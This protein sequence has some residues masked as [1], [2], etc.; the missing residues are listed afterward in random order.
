MAYS[1]KKL[2]LLS[3][4][5]PL[6]RSIT[7]FK[8]RFLKKSS[9]WS[10]VHKSKLKKNNIRKIKLIN[11]INKYYY[12]YGSG[13]YSSIYSNNRDSFIF[14]YLK[15]NKT[16]KNKINKKSKKTIKYSLFYFI[17]RFRWNPLF[18]KTISFL[19]CSFKYRNTALLSLSIARTFER[20]HKHFLFMSYFKKILNLL[21]LYYYRRDFGIVRGYIIE[22]NGKFNG[23][24][25]SKKKLISNGRMP[26]SMFDSNI[27]YSTSEANT[28]YGIFGIK[29]WFFII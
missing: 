6:K 20:N 9:N 11:F 24:N 13:L 16:Y 2:I 27:S 10:F 21:F 4:L 14:N 7:I 18:W 29:V 15:I 25:R 26:L 22:I 17:K 8:K 5:E 12:M 1:K 3:K 19:I 23:K 28:K